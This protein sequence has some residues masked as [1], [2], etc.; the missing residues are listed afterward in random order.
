MSQSR[1]FILQTLGSK[2][3]NLITLTDLLRQRLVKIFNER[4]KENAVA[5]A[6]FKKLQEERRA[7]G[8]VPLKDEPK[9]KDP[10][11]TL[12]D[13]AKTHVLYVRKQYKPYAAVGY[14]YIKREPDSGNIG[15]LKS[16]VVGKK[17]SFNIKGNTGGFLN[18]M[19][20]HIKINAYGDASGNTFYRYCNYPGVRIIEKTELFIDEERID[21]YTFNDVMFYAETELP[22]DGKELAF[23][24]MVG[25]QQPKRATYYHVDTEFTQVMFFADGPQTR[26]R[27]KK[28][29]DLWIPLLFWFNKDVAQSLPNRAIN[30]L[31]KRIDFTIADIDRVFR[32]EDI[33]G[34]PTGEAIDITLDTV[35]LYTNN[36]AVN[37]EIED[38]ILN[39]PSLSL[40]RVHKRFEK[41]LDSSNNTVL[42]NDIK[43]PTEYIR[44]GFKPQ[45]NINN[46]DLWHKYG[47]HTLQEAAIPAILQLP[48]VSYPRLEARTA[49]FYDIT[50]AEE[51][52]EFTATGV[53]IYPKIAASF[54]TDPMAFGY[55]GFYAPKDKCVRI[56]NFCVKPTDYN[57]SGYIQLSRN[58]EFRINYTSNYISMDT[59]AVL[60]MSAICINFLSINNNR[61]IL[62]YMT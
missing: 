50:C 13:V 10:R 52:I 2:Q 34:N 33:S 45:V 39:R 58:R 56:V 38:I 23:Q 41:I 1:Y 21:D 46:F 35:E 8:L 37:P 55:E 19:V 17:F 12:A 27:Y 3:D 18:D 30:S 14:E 31:Q 24:R 26:Q 57:P 40:I 48:G 6:K 53:P 9:L 49:S 62:K 29:L 28:S 36:I 20:L 32:A 60:L 5:K 7:A 54:F 11:P 47:V 4:S 61:A 22:R 43:F 42:I 15:R 59:K 44:F 51:T 16:G 25:Q